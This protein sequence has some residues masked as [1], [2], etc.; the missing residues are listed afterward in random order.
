[1]GAGLKKLDAVSE[2]FVAETVSLVDPAR[3]HVAA[4]V[5]ERFVDLTNGMRPCSPALLDVPLGVQ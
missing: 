1:M 2:D 5:L 4:E 3:P